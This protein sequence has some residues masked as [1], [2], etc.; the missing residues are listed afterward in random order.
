MG[1]EAKNRTNDGTTPEGMTERAGSPVASDR[2]RVV[3]A[4]GEAGGI[5]NP[6]EFHREP[7]LDETGSDGS[8]RPGG[9]PV[10]LKKRTMWRLMA[11]GA[12]LLLVALTVGTVFLLTKK[13]ST[14]DQ[15][16][17]LTVPSGANIRINSKDYGNSPVKIEQM[18]MGTYKVEISKEGFLPLVED[19]SIT[20]SQSLI[21]RKLTPSPPSALRGMP[22]EERIGSYQT[23][24]EEA[25]AKHRYGG[26]YTESALHYADL[27][28]ALDQSNVFAL[29]MRERVKAALH[30]S[31]RIAMRQKDHA[32]ALELY[33]ALVENFPEDEDAR[34]G[35]ARVESQIAAQRGELRELVAKAEA[36][37]RAGNL[38]EP[39]RASAYFFMKQAL[40][41]EK[42][43]AQARRISDEVKANL[44]A[45]ADRAGARGDLDTETK[46]YERLTELFPD[47]NQ[48][49]QK[50]AELREKRETEQF[51]ATDPEYRR[52]QGLASF[53]KEDYH[54]ALK[55]LEY[56][57]TNGR[58]TPEVI[59]AL[60]YC[61]WKL[62]ET[63]KA[64]LYFD[65]VPRNAG[66]HYRSAIA[67]LGDIASQRG[68][69]A[70]ALIQY[71]EARQLGG[72]LIYPV[73]KLDDK[74]EKIEKSLRE[75]ARAPEPIT[76]E[77][78]HLHGSLRGS[79]TGTLSISA[80]GVRY[81]SNEHN[82][83]ANFDGLGVT[84]SGNRITVKFSPKEQRF[85]LRSEAD[86]ERFQ[87]A[88]RRYQQA[89]SSANR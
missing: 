46:E 33:D 25:F 4:V 16:V 35:K 66:D 83:A 6:R 3:E 43:D 19:I 40:V 29:D 61:Q 75:K 20:E 56:A 28:I 42:Q 70:K 14:V 86:G 44:R 77:V 21:E 47:D 68:D 41:I 7:S 74:I 58:G 39:A 63:D 71:K 84:V 51:K 60:A 64:I 54:G 85:A 13:P 88:Q 17:I 2:V 45:S 72:S 37:L 34:S 24:A 27:I 73:D 1:P 32:Q 76:I 49:A 23:A 89:G 26:V 8:D 78:R 55:N 10:E 15:L 87:E 30:R 22:A 12:A 5:P 65:R 62:G 36:A 57:A 38:I 18:E 67:A 11:A 59:F 31:A 50:F 53:G 81:D 52:Q 79:C 69:T 82:Y 48:L 9:R 80:R